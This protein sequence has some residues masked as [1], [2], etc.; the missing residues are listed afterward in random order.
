MRQDRLVGRLKAGVP[1]RDEGLECSFL[2][3]LRD[4]EQVLPDVMPAKEIEIFLSELRI[5][6]G[7]PGGRSIHR[8]R[9]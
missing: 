8:A 9:A 7:S 4:L 3:I 6:H 2:E 5:S 1:S